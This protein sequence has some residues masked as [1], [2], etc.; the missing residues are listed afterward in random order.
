MAGEKLT[1]PHQT[2]YTE[3]IQHTNLF[4]KETINRM[5]K[6]RTC[7]KKIFLTYWVSHGGA[8]CELTSLDEA[9][10]VFIHKSISEV[11]DRKPQS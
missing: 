4:E 7:E 8:K 11:H 1:R 3:M 9:T 10:L 2:K 5:Q 6:K